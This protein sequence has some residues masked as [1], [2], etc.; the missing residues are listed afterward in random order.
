MK[1]WI[2]FLVLFSGCTQGQ[3]PL[4]SQANPQTT[5]R[6]NPFTKTIDVFNS[7]DVSITIESFAGK[8]KDG[9]SWELK[10]LQ[11]IDSASTVRQANVAQLELVDRITKTSIS[12]IF[13]GFSKMISEGLMP[14]K[15][16]N[17]K[18]ETPIGTSDITTGGGV[19][20][21]NPTPN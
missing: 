4:W 16:A 13:N 15:G 11:L 8:T 20:P 1:K 14:I 10:N 6:L 7:K 3:S 17:A 19:Q 12:E 2:S 5:I 18:L 21:S 9:A